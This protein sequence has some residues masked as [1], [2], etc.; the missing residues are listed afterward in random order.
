[1]GRDFQNPVH[2]HKGENQATPDRDASSDIASTASPGSDRDPMTIR[3]GEDFGDLGGI[4]RKCDRF[5]KRG[6]HPGIRRVGLEGGGVE[7]DNPF[8]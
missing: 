5:R 8:G 2:I 7:A 3:I 4:P 1:L 6:G